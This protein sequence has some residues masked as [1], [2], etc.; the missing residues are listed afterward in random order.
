MNKDR[1]LIVEDDREIR[2]LLSVLSDQMV[3]ARQL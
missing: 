2:N 1:I 3:Q